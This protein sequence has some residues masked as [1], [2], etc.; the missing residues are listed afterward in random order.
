LT[1]GESGG[2]PR[3]IFVVA[4][5]MVLFGLAEV[6]TG[7]T[8]NFLNVISATTSVT[9]TA[10]SATIGIFYIVAGLLVLT[11]RRWGAA[12]AIVLLCADI[13]GRAALVVTGLYPF[14]GI[15]AASIVAGTAIAAIFALYIGLRWSK[16]N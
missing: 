15:D 8:G 9:Y 7:L 10:A 14:S 5:L 16:F 1:A 13:A 11:M 2:R 3:G 4:L 6:A 12:L